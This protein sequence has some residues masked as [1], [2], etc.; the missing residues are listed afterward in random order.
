MM[1]AAGLKKPDISILSDEFLAEVRGM[2]QRN[3]AV[4]LLRKLLTGEMK[5]R[6]CRNVVQARVLRCA[7][8][9]RQCSEGASK[10]GQKAIARGI[11]PKMSERFEVSLRDRA[12]R[13]LAL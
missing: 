2:P 3:L 7:G 1:S 8:G 13:F 6:L 11:A 10:V 5:S 12:R 9:E 4:E